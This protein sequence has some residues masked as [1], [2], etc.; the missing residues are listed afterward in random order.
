MIRAIIEQHTLDKQTY[1]DIMAMVTDDIRVN[2]IGYGKRTSLQDVAKIIEQS[3][4]AI[5]RAAS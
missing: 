4:G 2:R 1:N 5:K 3:V